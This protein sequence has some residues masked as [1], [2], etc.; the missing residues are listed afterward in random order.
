M[1]SITTSSAIDFD[2]ENFDASS[3]C[4]RDIAHALSQINRYLG[5]TNRSYSV[6]EHCWHMATYFLDSSDGLLEPD[7]DRRR[8]AMLALVHDAHEAYIGDMPTPLKQY[9][10][11]EALTKLQELEKRIDAQIYSALGIAPPS[12]RERFLVKTL[13]IA[14]RRN[15]KN[16]LFGQQNPLLIHSICIFSHQQKPSY[17]RDMWLNLYEELVGRNQGLQLD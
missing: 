8:M 2:Y 15:E 4:L 14:I 3:I 1:P 10:G 9:L 7:D 5:H 13:D 16:V 12:E 6:A 11:P 17:Y